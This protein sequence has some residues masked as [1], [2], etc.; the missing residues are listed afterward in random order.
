MALQSELMRK[1]YT[2]N[3]VTTDFSF[4][5]AIDD[6]TDIDVY[7]VVRATKVPTTLDFVTHYDVIGAYDPLTGENDDYSDGVTIECVTAPA[8]TLDLV[9]VRRPPDTQD[10]VLGSYVA[11]VIERALDK[12]VMMI[13]HLRSR[14]DRSIGFADSYTGSFDPT[15]PPAHTADSVMK[16][17]ADNDAFEWITVADL[18]EEL[19][20]AG[21]QSLQDHFDDTTDAHDASAISLT[22]VGAVVATNVQTAIQELDSDLTAHVNDT[23]DAH[24]GSAVTN[25]PS[26]NLAATTVQGALNELQTDVDTRATTTALNDHISDSADAH[27]AS[28]ITNT[29]AGTIAATTVQT[30]LN[31]LDTDKLPVTLTTKGDLISRDASAP[32][33]LAVGT[34]GM[35]L[36]ADSTQTLGVKW[37][38]ASGG[39][40]GGSLKWVEDTDAPIKVID[41]SI[42]VYEFQNALTNYLW[43][44]IKVPETYVAGVQIFL[45]TYWYTAGTSNNV[46]MQTQATLIR[47]ATDVISSTTNQ[48]TSTNAAVTVSGATENEPQKVTHDLTDSSGQINGVAVAAGDLIKVRLT[49]AT[50]TNTAQVYVPVYA[51][52]VKSS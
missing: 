40:G 12:I 27:A 30:A 50:D 21:S 7:T 29:P 3:G 18:S 45:Y 32:G 4:P 14:V 23:T 52:E 31:E 1:Q 38:N 48:R 51:A 42:E 28:A 15:I 46:L 34:N 11:A 41:S 25:T 20:E 22:P 35:V 26:G 44:I 10:S 49:R 39:G 2:G 8:A 19:L 33:R 6:A 43:A 37:A 47:T 5:W 9:I 24:G 13:Q 17:N 36:T 16:S